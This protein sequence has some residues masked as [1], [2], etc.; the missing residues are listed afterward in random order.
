MVRGM[1]FHVFVCARLP[2]KYLNLEVHYIIAT[3]VLF[4]L[5]TVLESVASADRYIF[6]QHVQVT[7]SS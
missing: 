3:S 7:K 5:S 1:P 2:D 4:H 6:R